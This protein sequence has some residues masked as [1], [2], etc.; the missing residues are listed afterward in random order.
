MKTTIMALAFATSLNAA[1]VSADT[2]SAREAA[3]TKAASIPDKVNTVA[4]ICCFHFG[5]GMTDLVPGS[6]MGEKHDCV[7]PIFG[8]EGATL[9]S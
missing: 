6:R 3:K 7:Q 2:D 5:N 8:P 9:T 1:A 4:Q